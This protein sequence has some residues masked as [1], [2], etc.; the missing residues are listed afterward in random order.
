MN[1]SFF[2][3]SSGMH[4]FQFLILTN[5]RSRSLYRE[6]HTYRGQPGYQNGGRGRPRAWRTVNW[7]ATFSRMSSSGWSAKWPGESNVSV[8][9]ARCRPCE[10]RA[11]SI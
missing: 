11:Y 8:N 5:A 3:T 9:P 1:S 2:R 4:E 10:D 6:S 7:Q